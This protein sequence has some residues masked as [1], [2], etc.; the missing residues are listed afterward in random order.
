MMII[1]ACVSPPRKGRSRSPPLGAVVVFRERETRVR[2]ASNKN[3]DGIF[4]TLRAAVSFVRALYGGPGGW[5]DGSRRRR[6]KKKKIKIIGT[7][8]RNRMGR[9][10]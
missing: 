5:G 6:G 10:V 8:T 2:R 1:V 3:A 9:A 4:G 7:T